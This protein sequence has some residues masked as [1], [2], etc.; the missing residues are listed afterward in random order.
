MA[1]IMC[2]I[3]DEEDLPLIIPSYPHRMLVTFTLSK[4]V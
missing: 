4:S 3:N 2:P 1:E